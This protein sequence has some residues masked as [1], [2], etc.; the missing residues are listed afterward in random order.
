MSLQARAV[1]GPDLRPLPAVRVRRLWPPHGRS[2]RRRRGPFHGPPTMDVRMTNPGEGD[3][4]EQQSDD[5]LAPPQQ[6][7]GGDVKRGTSDAEGA[8]QAQ[9]LDA[10]MRGNPDARESLVSSHLGWVEGAARERA[11]RGLSEG[12]LIQEGSLG[13]MK[14]IEE[15]PRS[16]RAEF[17]PFAREQVSDQMERALAQEG[18][19]QDE[20]RRLI[21]AAEDFQQA[22]FAL[23]RELGR[24]ATPAELA[25][26]LEWAQDRTD[27]VAEMVAEARRRHDEELLEYL[28]PEELDLDRL[29]EPAAAEGGNQAPGRPNGAPRDQGQGPSTT[30]R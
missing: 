14:A 12:D 11:G 7:P 22:E 18:Q 28:D 29:I 21:Q 13:L 5:S 3:P 1:S 8:E 17:E 2:I 25:V 24:E 16:G 26:K 15:F 19:A 27:A 4:G 23:R 10:A 20:N 30:E 9:L 6:L